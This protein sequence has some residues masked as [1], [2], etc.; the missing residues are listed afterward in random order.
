MQ[1]MVSLAE[2]EF[3]MATTDTLESIK[4][5]YS[6][7]R[8]E[9]CCEAD[10]DDSV[11]YAKVRLFHCFTAIVEK[12]CPATAER[13][14]LQAD[15]KLS[16]QDYADLYGLS[17]AYWGDQLLD[18]IDRAAALQEKHRTDRQIFVACFGVF[19]TLVLV[20]TLLMQ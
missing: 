2:R 8:R 11:L 6:T 7:Y 19:F 12:S 14:A 15:S 5:D 10:F 13:D 20:L 16:G 1:C 9:L 3:I 18:L 17:S 4:R